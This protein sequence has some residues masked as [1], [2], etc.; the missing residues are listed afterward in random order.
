MI[1]RRTKSLA[2]GGTLLLS[3]VVF[4]GV[5]GAVGFGPTLD[6][7]RNNVRELI[8]NEVPPVSEGGGFNASATS[9]SQAEL[10]RTRQQEQKA[11][12]ESIV[13]K[14]TSYEEEKITNQ[15]GKIDEYLTINNTFRDVSFCDDKVLKSRQIVIDGVD[16]VQRIAYL[17][18]NKLT[19]KNFDGS[20]FGQG[21]CN[22][23]PGNV[24]HTRGVLETRDV[25]VVDGMD[26]G[27]T[28]ITGKTYIVFLSAMQFA[29][30]PSMNE[31]FSV[32]GYA[33]ALTKI[34]NLK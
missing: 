8:M 23:I 16:V 29:I 7:L 2:I 32:G 17:A 26:D 27:S 31:I 12:V 21:I 9:T 1:N 34:G 15:F 20:T 30:S 6:D 22:S 24:V 4:V 18:S 10:A 19:E 11:K 3:V 5:A 25:T 13:S 14:A 33:G 28:V